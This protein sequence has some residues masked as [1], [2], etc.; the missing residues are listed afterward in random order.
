[1]A[2]CNKTAIIIGASSGIGKALAKKLSREG[3]AIGLVSRRTE[4]LQELQKELTTPTFIR[5]IDITKSSSADDLRLLFKEM[6]NI[7]LVIVN[8]GVF[9][10]NPEYVWEKEESTVETNVMGFTRMAHASMEH[11]L[12][13]GRGHLVGISSISA[14]RG[15]GDSP[16]YSASKAF[17]SNYLE[18]LR[19]KAFRLK[20]DIYVTDIQPGWV[21]TDMAKGHETFWMA[22][23]DVAAEQIYSSIKRKSSHAYITRRWCLY[24]WMLKLLPRPIYDQFFG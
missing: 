19:V 11:F 14:I 2:V 7:D 12:K 8:A 20:K 13:Q 18:G 22:P 10:N 1:M 16:S 23:V 21:D 9:L 15:E 17:V 6:G 5:K 3:Y 4:L 24:A